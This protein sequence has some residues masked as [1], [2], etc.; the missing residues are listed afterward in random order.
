MNA[1]TTSQRG[2]EL[3]QRTNVY[4]SRKKNIVEMNVKVRF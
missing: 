3:L 1:T 4:N 2:D